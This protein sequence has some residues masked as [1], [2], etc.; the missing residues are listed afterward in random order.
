M[1]DYPFPHTY[2]DRPDRAHQRGPKPWPLR[3][4]MLRNTYFCPITGCHFWMGFVDPKTGYGRIWHNNT[5]LLVHRVAVV[6]AG[7]E[8]PEGLCIDHLCKNR[9]CCNPDHLDIV[10][11]KVN[12][13]RGDG[14][15]AANAKKTCCPRCGGEFRVRTCGRRRCHACN[16]DVKRI[17]RNTLLIERANEG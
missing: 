12:V 5:N 7:R 15:S 11:Q 6:L 2:I 4:K 14:I 1:I 13:L 9:S 8:I 17:R 3:D 10:T 16:V